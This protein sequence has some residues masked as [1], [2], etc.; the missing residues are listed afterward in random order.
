MVKIEEVWQG[1]PESV[2]LPEVV[3]TSEGVFHA[4]GVTPLVI[5]DEQMRAAG[6]KKMRRQVSEWEE[7]DD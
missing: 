3:V 2:P 1:T 7:V 6:Y 5:T 4:D